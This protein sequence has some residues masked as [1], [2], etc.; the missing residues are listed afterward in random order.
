MFDAP[1][2]EQIYMKF[3]TPGPVQDVFQG[4]FNS[5]SKKENLTPPSTKHHTFFPTTCHLTNTAIYIKTQ[6]SVWPVTFNWTIP[7]MQNIKRINSIEERPSWEANSSLACQE[8]PRILWSPKVHCLIHNGPRLVLIP[9][10][11]SLLH[12]LPSYFFIN[13]FNVI[14][15]PKATISFLHVSPQNPV[16]PSSE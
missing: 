3:S 10:Q 6:T 11:T 12:A 2:P 5:H 13:Y 1:H 9:R 15:S 14:I 4:H 8:I 16:F 7:N